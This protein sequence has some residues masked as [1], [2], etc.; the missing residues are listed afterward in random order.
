MNHLKEYQSFLDKKFPKNE[1]V[2]ISQLVDYIKTNRTIPK[3][4]LVIMASGDAKLRLKIL[5]K[6]TP[7]K[8]F[9]TPLKIN[10]LGKKKGITPNY[11]HWFLSQD[12]MKTF[13]MKFATGAVILRIPRKLIYELRVPTPANRKYITKS[14][15]TIIE[16]HDNP[17]FKLLNEFYSD[18]LLNVKNKR[19]RTAIILAGA[20]GE[21]ILYQ[22][23]LEQDVDKSILNN[24]R[25]LGFGKLVTY[26]KLLKL[27]KKLHF[28]ISQF[29]ELQKKRNN[30]I[31]VGLASKKQQEFK[32]VDLDC[33]NQ[34][35]KHF[36]I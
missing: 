30:A 26:V 19:Y 1:K 28:P 33:I 22:L 24:D 7:N 10:A 4:T 29:K 11:L 18:Y 13:L 5:E 35:I 16:N 14:N 32:K 20:I 27:D 9:S 36:G 3:G 17:F 31:H 15:E 8:G 21:T 23:V 34:I 6:D 2:P 25:S 12:F